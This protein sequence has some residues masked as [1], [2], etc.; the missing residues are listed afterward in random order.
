MKTIT[1]WKQAHQFEA[2]HEGNTIKI[3]GDK[4]KGH[5]PKALLLSA[6]AGCS[7]IDVVDILGKMKIEFTSLRMETEATLSDEHPK[8]F[9]GVHITYYIQSAGENEDRIKKAIDLSLEKYCGV[10]AMLKKNSPLH[11]TLVIEP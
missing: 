1:T 8:V 7:G 10:S 5:G 3:D 6:L 4:E 9:T 2:D 11:Y